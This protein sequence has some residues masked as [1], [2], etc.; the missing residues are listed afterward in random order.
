MI[1]STAMGRQKAVCRKQKKIECR[2]QN[3]EDS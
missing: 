1:P 3:A 2:E